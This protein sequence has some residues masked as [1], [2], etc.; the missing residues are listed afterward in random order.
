MSLHYE[1]WL[2]MAKTGIPLV[3]IVSS[4][5]IIFIQKRI[6]DSQR[7]KL[8][9]SEHRKYLRLAILVARQAMENSATLSAALTTNFEVKQMALIL[10]VLTDRRGAIDRLVLKDLDE[11]E[12]EQVFIIRSNFTKIISICRRIELD[13][14]IIPNHI[15]HINELSL[16]V[17]NS[18]GLLEK[19]DRDLNNKNSIIMQFLN[20]LFDFEKKAVGQ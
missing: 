18:V 5:F 2:E 7:E 15:Y 8:L 12:A 1:Q 20:K 9:R 6:A 11:L 14:S 13:V 19:S 4:Y 3:A 17:A 10:D 16:Q